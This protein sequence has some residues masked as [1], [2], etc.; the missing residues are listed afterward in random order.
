MNALYASG[1]RPARQRILRDAART[2][3][4]AV[5]AYYASVLLS[6]PEPHWACLAAVIA[7]R[8]HAGAARHIGAG[9][10]PGA[11]AGAAWA[12]IVT[13]LAGERIPDGLA[14]ALTVALPALLAAWKPLC[15]SAL[16][17]ALIVLAAGSHAAWSA[18]WLRVA[19]LGTGAVTAIVVVALFWPR[20]AHDT[21]KA[22]AGRIRR[23]LVA[24]LDA[25][26]HGG[27]APFTAEML[28]AEIESL[29]KLAFVAGRE[30]SGQDN[31]NAL[32][33]AAANA[34]C[35][36]FAALRLERARR[37]T[38][39]AG[40]EAG[41]ATEAHAVPGHGSGLADLVRQDMRELERALQGRHA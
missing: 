9:R 17:S 11:L 10:V 31:T 38:A 27:E 19:A 16:V 36:V 34:V 5:L 30:K 37:E 14:V 29:R 20:S 23:M 6:L 8:G 25:A 21:A 28:H 40:T 18:A 32:Y 33:M 12:V 26:R 7:A 24:V 4:A 41:N 3:A 2:L 15:R 35:S 13:A 1:S 22:L 39:A